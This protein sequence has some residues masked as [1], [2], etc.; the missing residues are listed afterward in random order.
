MPALQ[1]ALGE[2]LRVCRRDDCP[3]HT[4]RNSQGSGRRKPL[5]GG[6]LPVRQGRAQLSDDLRREGARLVAIGRERH[7]NWS[8]RESGHL[9]FRWSG[10]S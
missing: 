7:L 3:A 9:I 5:T 8:V 2:Q 4:E 10:Y 6:E 1:P